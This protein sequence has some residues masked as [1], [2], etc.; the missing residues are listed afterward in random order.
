MIKS[1]LL[2][3]ELKVLNRLDGLNLLLII[4]FEMTQLKLPLHYYISISVSF[5]TL[6]VQAI[7]LEV[8]LFI[9]YVHLVSISFY[10]SAKSIQSS[11][12]KESFFYTILVNIS[13]NTFSYA[14]SVYLT[15]KILLNLN[16]F[17]IF[18]KYHFVFMNQFFYVQRVQKFP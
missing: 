2:Y 15:E 16:E 17:I 18:I 6:S 5:E 3:R 11:I 13:S 1:N 4:I 7:V 14:S 9:R 12:Y 10:N 8:S